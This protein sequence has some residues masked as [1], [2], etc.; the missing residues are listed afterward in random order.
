MNPI[1]QL[2]LVVERELAREQ[3]RLN[4][5]LVASAEVTQLTSLS[6][7]ILSR[8]RESCSP[9]ADSGRKIDL[10]AVLQLAGFA[11]L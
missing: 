6:E 11:N 7:R 10:A 2:E 5:P 9:N 3:G 4:R 8:A 1:V